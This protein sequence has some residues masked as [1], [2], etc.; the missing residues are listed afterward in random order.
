[1]PSL[2]AYTTVHAVFQEMIEILDAE[3]VR[4]LRTSADRAELATAHRGANG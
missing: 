1:M 2:K 4:A 3:H